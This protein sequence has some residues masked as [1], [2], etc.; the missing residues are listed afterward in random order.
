MPRRKSLGSQSWS[1]HRTWRPQ[2]DRWLIRVYLSGKLA[3]AADGRN[4]K[5]L[6][7]EN[8][9]LSGSPLSRL[10]VSVIASISSLC[11]RRYCDQAERFLPS[12][13]YTVMELRRWADLVLQQPDALAGVV[14]N[15]HCQTVP[16]V[17]AA[18]ITA[19][20][21]R[22]TDWSRPH[23]AKRGWRLFIRL[24]RM[25]SRAFKS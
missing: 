23:R 10:T 15:P 2:M 7:M 9:R 24:L 8:S 21:F 16:V 12:R 19:R 5:N 6:V 4:L 13:Q 20:A 1:D 18:G 3:A 17:A 22:I 11:C 14:L 25:L